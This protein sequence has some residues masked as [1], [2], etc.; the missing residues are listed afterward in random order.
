MS[1]FESFVKNNKWPNAVIDMTYCS[2]ER[3]G[4]ELKDV[5]ESSDMM[6][7]LSVFTVARLMLKYIEDRADLYLQA[8]NV[9]LNDI[10]NN[11][12]QRN[13]IRSVTDWFPIE[14]EYFKRMD[15]ICV[16]L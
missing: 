13:I 16:S 8:S 3:M 11:Q 1:W 4:Y 14:M 2:L 15:Y 5:R 6:T 7:V 10:P 12:G 9:K